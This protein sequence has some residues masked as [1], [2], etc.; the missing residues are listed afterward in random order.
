MALLV[1]FVLVRSA[2]PQSSIKVHGIVID[3]KTGEPLPAAN[4][5]VEGA[6]IGAATNFSGRFFIENLLT[7]DYTLLVSFV[8]YKSVRKSVSVTS[9]EPSFILIRLLPSVIPMP[10]VEIAAER[11]MRFSDNGLIFLTRDEIG[12][13][14][15][16]DLGDLLKTIGGVQVFENGGKKSIQIRGA[17]ANQ[18]LVLLDG[19]KLNDQL[20]GEVDLAQTP[21]HSI[22]S[23]EI[24]KGSAAEYG[25][26]ALGGVI[27]ITTLNAVSNIQSIGGETGAFGY[28]KWQ[29]AVGRAFGSFDFSASLHSLDND[30][31]FFYHYHDPASHELSAQR[32]NSDVH[33]K[34]LFGR[35]GFSKGA[36]KGAVKVQS[37][38]SDR[39]TPGKVYY[40]TPYARILSDRRTA[41]FHYSFVTDN[42]RIKTN[43]GASSYQTENL[44]L[45]QDQEAAPFGPTPEFHFRNDLFSINFSAT[46]EHHTASWISTLFGYDADRVSYKDRNRLVEQARSIGI[47]EDRSFGLFLKQEFS[48][49]LKSVRFAATP[50]IRYDQAALNSASQQR[51]ERQWNP[52][53][54]LF[55]SHGLEQQ[56]YMRAEANRGFR[57]PTFAD[58][59]YQDFRVQGKSDLL[60]EK[61]TNVEFAIG[62][63]LNFWATLHFDVSF[64]R[65][66]IDDMIVWRLG[67]FEFFRPYNTD[68]ELRG[69]EYSLHLQ[70]PENRIGLD[71]YYS[72]LQALNKNENVTLYNKMLPYRPENTFK[73][74][75]RYGGK[76]WQTTAGLR[77]V[78]RRN[79][80]EANT[81]SMPAY[82]ILDWT[83]ELTIPFKQVD[84]QWRAAIFNLLD[85]RYEIL[86]DM[87]LPG[88]EWRFGVM[89]KI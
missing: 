73:A 23:V 85:E 64:Y 50:V 80:T 76:K 72:I 55:A 39:G 3:A 16:S 86:R 11:E 45:R 84:V 9:G 44:N 10:G 30:G 8:G 71:C 17:R 32:Q 12:R 26:G 47:A 42:L 1:V 78:G 58:L 40:W 18:T 5:Q 33:S 70:S 81:K 82:S 19:V 63:H 28:K 79:I 87:P 13:A 4:V 7:G 54:R 15:A 53:L 89:L 22:E 60:P 46:I 62:A 35:L 83:F 21:L 75:F 61:S 41:T 48:H 37:F 36:H 38:T 56:I 43:A 65:N 29:A 52:G 69:S 31:R 34:S 24:H 2:L 68:A 57:M 74:N 66:K 6:A 14:H 20:T 77:R 49:Q 67:S 27:K 59:F 51:F 88:R 25:D